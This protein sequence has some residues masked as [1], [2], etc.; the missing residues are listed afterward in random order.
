LGFALGFLFQR[1]LNFE[2]GTSDFQSKHPSLIMD[3]SELLKKQR[4]NWQKGLCDFRNNFLEHR[5][6]ELTTFESYYQPERAELLFDSA[7]RTMAD[8]FHVFIESHFSP[9]LSIRE[10]PASERDPLRPRCFK[11]FSANPPDR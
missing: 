8:L 11:S 5:C 4:T 3:V 1:D 6:E 9:T 7:W 2:K 10:I